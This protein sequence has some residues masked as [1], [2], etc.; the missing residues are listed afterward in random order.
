MSRGRASS[1]ASSKEREEL[2]RANRMKQLNH[3]A[4]G[5]S[6]GSYNGKKL[7]VAVL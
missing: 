7:A 1:L 4:E 5:H 3:Q 2:A 6:M